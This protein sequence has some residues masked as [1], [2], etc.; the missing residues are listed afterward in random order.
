MNTIALEEII[1]SRVHNYK[2]DYIILN[3]CAKEEGYDSFRDFQIKNNV[4]MNYTSGE[5]TLEEII[6]SYKKFYEINK[7]LPTVNDLTKNDY[8]KLQ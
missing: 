3:K 1:S 2:F 7:R 8:N 5:I 4:N 6:N